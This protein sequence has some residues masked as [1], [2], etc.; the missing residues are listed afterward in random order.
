MSPLRSQ[1]PQVFLSDASLLP[2]YSTSG[3]VPSVGREISS[4][5][6]AGRALV[7]VLVDDLHLAECRGRL[8]EAPDRPVAEVDRQAALDR[9]VALDDLDVEALL[10]LLPDGRGHAGAEDAAHRVVGVVRTLRLAVD[11]GRHAAEQVE[12]GAAVLARDVPQP[13]LG[14]LATD[15]GAPLQHQ[16]GRQGQHLRVTV[17]EREPRVGPFVLPPLHQ[18]RHGG[19]LDVAARRHHDPLR[20]ARGAGRVDDLERILG[21]LGPDLDH[22]DL[23]VEHRA[24]RLGVGGVA[25]CHDAGL[26]AALQHQQPLELR[27]LDPGLRRPVPGRSR[28]R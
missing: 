18:H 20:I 24:Q 26:L 25:R 16:A 27:R 12:D 6:D 5:D 17:G 3:R 14:E 10:E 1:P 11:R 28:R 21:A 7:A 4:P 19:R 22:G 9:A 15:H 2:K 13:R 23:G 8:A